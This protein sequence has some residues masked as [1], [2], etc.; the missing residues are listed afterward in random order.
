MKDEE[1]I[2]QFEACTLPTENFHHRDHVKLV[3]LYLQRYPA[4][5][6]L[7]RF[8]EGLKRFAA[9][10]G[11]HNLY[12]ETITWAYVFLIHE[13]LKRAGGKQRWEEFIAANP[14]LFD[15][16]N[17]ILKTYYRDETLRSELARKV[18]V[19]PDQSAQVQVVGTK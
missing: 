3:W 5:E 12:H 1:F 13:R 17:N 14:D 2:K 10:N 18:F 16:Q 11:K 15:W 19:F 4:L 7:V 6:T 9:A 8:S